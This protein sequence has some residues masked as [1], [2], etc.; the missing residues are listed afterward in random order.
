MPEALYNLTYN[1]KLRHYQLC[2][3]FVNGATSSHLNS[4][5]SIQAMR[6]PLGTVNLLGIH[7]AHF[8]VPTKGSRTEQTPSQVESEAGTELG[9]SCGKVRCSTN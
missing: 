1:F 8:Y 7:I 3:S 6:L 4:L 9:S 2:H 5:G